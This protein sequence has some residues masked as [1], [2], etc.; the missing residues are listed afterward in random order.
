MARRSSRALAVLLLAAVL[1]GCSAS[2][3]PATTAVRTPPAS[4]TR[5][6][7]PTLWLCRPGMGR[8]PCEGDLGTTVI[9]PD[10]SRSRQPFQPAADPKIDCFYAYPT[11]SQAA[12]TNAP[13]APAPEI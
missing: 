6:A 4:P 10:G 1:G 11:V 13:L 5:E 2:S 9:S 7:E 12:T 8:N 3:T